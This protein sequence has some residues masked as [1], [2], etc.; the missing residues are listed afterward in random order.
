ME[1]QLKLHEAKM[2]EKRETSFNA[3]I[4]NSDVTETS[5]RNVPSTKKRILFEVNSNL[6]NMLYDC[7]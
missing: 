4:D 1:L 3:T 7:E 5:T 2:N 6:E